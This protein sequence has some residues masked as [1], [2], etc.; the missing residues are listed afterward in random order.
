MRPY[1][2]ISQLDSVT[3]IRKMP[4]A[5][6]SKTESENLEEF[7]RTEFGEIAIDQRKIKHR[8]RPCHRVQSEH[9]DH[10][11]RSVFQS[12]FAGRLRVVR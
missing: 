2:P 10:C 12:G 5:W 7:L 3:V 9:L 8:I 6:A 11:S 1:A 4:D